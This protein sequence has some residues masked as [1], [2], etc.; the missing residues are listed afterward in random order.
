MTDVPSLGGEKTSRDHWDAGWTAMP[1]DR[2]WSP[3]D[4]TLSDLKRLLA[5]EIAPGSTLLEAGFAP[6]K[7]LAWAALASK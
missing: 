3:F 4:P 1:T 5:R 6:G 2:F 7:M